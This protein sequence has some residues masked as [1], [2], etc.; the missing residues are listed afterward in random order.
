MI[1]LLRV[2]GDSLYPDIQAGDFVVLATSPLFLSRLQ[3][4]DV[5]V[6]RH[7]VHGILIKRVTRTTAEDVFVA[8]T[9]KNSLD[10]HRLGSI[11]RQKIVGK[12][13]WHIK[14]NG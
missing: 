10:S 14:K 7:P 5:I 9:H 1:R 3:V 11:P 13:I 2:T 12:M 4:G 8:G 6:F